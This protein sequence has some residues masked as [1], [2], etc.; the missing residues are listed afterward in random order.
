[1][2]G[3]ASFVFMGGGGGGLLALYSCSLDTLH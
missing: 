2:A 1:M 3:I